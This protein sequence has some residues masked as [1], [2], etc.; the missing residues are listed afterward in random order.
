LKRQIGEIGL[1]LAHL[2][3]LEKLEEEEFRQSPEGIYSMDFRHLVTVRQDRSDID[4]NLVDA[5]ELA[6]SL[7]RVPEKPLSSQI[8]EMPPDGIENVSC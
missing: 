1:E 5:R 2:V 6:T 4:L 3:V 7:P 8:G